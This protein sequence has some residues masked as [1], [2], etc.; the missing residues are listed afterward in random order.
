MRRV[1]VIGTS[2]SGKT[3]ISREIARTLGCP[4][5]ELDAIFHQPDWAPLDRE[6]FGRLVGAVADGA[7]WVIDGNYSVIRPIV[8]SQ[9]D[10]VIWLDLPKRIVMRRLVWR[11]LRRVAGR[12]V[13]WNGNREHWR[14]V[15][16][17]KPEESVI[18]WA[19]HKHAEYRESY[20][21]A[22][23]DPANKH[24]NF[25]RLT[26]PASIRQFLQALD[27]VWN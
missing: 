7:T 2:G 18:C 16:S 27:N 26:S 6:E 8:W 12:E 9:A 20:A 25:I 15:F 13:L 10:T 5:L 11:T 4:L 21:A 14:N 19:W 1:S 17:W 24:L 23:A 22:A 3:T